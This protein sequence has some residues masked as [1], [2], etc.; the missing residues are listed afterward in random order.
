MNKAKAKDK[1][2]MIVCVIEDY[3]FFVF[4]KIKKQ[5]RKVQMV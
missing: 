1:M 4:L 3:I 5:S 2:Y